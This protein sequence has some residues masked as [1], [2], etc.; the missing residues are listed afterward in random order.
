MKEIT[1]KLLIIAM[2][3]VCT[4]ILHAG[5]GRTGAQIINLGGGSRASA[6]SE[7]STTMSGDLM[8]TLSNPGGLAMMEEVQAQ[9]SY[10]D[11]S[12]LFGEGSEGLY[13][14]IFASGG[15]IDLGFTDLPLGVGGITLQM[16]G[17]GVI[18]VT[19]DSPEVFRQEELGTNW[20]A[21]ISYANGISNILQIGI[22]GKII[23]QELTEEYTSN[24]YAF[25]AGFQLSPI[26]LYLTPTRD[27][28]ISG[29]QTRN[30]PPNARFTLGTAVRNVGTRV[31]FE[32]EEQSDPLP[33][34]LQFGASTDLRIG[35]R[36][37]I[38]DPVIPSSF[39][40]LRI[41][42]GA[43][44]CAAIDK[45][46]DEK[47]EADEEFMEKQNLT[48][49]EL[50]AKRGVGIHAFRWS[51]L[52]KRIGS[53]LWLIDILA[54]RVGYRDEPSINLPDFSDHVSYGLGL[55]LP[56]SALLI[57]IPVSE[58]PSFID[59]VWR[60]SGRQF[61]LQLDLALTPGGGPYN[62]RL[63][64]FSFSFGF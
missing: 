37:L 63:T 14:S 19:T 36:D 42:F 25:D 6:L 61:F 20:A 16:Q 50:K 15:P 11:Y 53:E 48:W 55:K 2:I 52:D 1:L 57:A 45:L 3:C 4:N 24:A 35:L 46:K 60:N 29:K 32:D 17:Q 58:P 26:N 27:S 31:Q 40:L 21:T 23:H 43:E 51:N 13:Y 34:Q 64:T 39:N 47:D 9:I 10:T 8:C 41:R 22:N 44:L 49:D 62:N 5:V 30:H 38:D 7:A 59:Q 33:R 56:I 18:D 28:N 54:L 12:E